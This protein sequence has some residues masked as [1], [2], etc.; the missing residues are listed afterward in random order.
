MSLKHPSKVFK[1]ISLKEYKINHTRVYKKKLRV[2][3]LN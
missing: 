2:D 3:I 1:G